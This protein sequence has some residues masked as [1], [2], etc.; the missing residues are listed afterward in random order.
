MSHDKTFEST[1]RHFFRT[2]CKVIW[3]VKNKQKYRQL[4]HKVDCP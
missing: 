1:M 3:N 4:T 2:L